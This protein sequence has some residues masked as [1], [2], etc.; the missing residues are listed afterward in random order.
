MKSSGDCQRIKRVEGLAGT[1]PVPG[2]KS[3]SHRAVLLG[4]I[5]HGISRVRNFLRSQ[6]CLSTMRCMKA[7]GVEIIEPNGSTLEIGGVGL[8]GLKEPQDVLNVSNSGTTIRLLSG[9][10]AG[11]EFHAVL[12]GDDS[13]RRRPMLRVVGPLREMGAKIFGRE[14]GRFAPL[15]IMGSDLNPSSYTLPVASAQVKSALLLAGLY[16]T[17]ET[18]VKEPAPTRD[19]TERMLRC[20]GKEVKSSDGNIAIRGGGELSPLDLEVPGDISS[21]AFFLVSGLVCP[22][23]QV[24]I[25]GVGVNPTRTGIIDVLSEMGGNISVA[26]ERAEGGEPV[27]DLQVESSE[28]RGIDI[29]GGMIPRV[30]DELPVIAVAATQAKGKTVVRDAQ[31]LRVKETDRIRA[32]VEELSKLGAKIEESDDGFSVEGPTELRGAKC[33]SHDDHRIA[34]ALAVAGLVAEGETN[35]TNADCVDVSFPNFFETLTNLAR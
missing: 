16:T 9:L 13:I 26:N 2:D 35:I 22:D 29:H 12:T 28:L 8:H 4:S 6:D 31:E 34:M 3:I 30:I 1:L 24:T 33:H 14:D 17:G 18:V 7:L 25:R 32:S 21:A 10:L 27:A 5:S 20:M 23:S 15:S 11:Q 19:H